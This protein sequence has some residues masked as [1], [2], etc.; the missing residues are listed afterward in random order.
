MYEISPLYH[1]E[2]GNRGT[3]FFKKGNKL[4]KEKNA[5]ACTLLE[6]PVGNSYIPSNSEWCRR[7]QY[8][9][10]EI[11]LGLSAVVCGAQYP[12]L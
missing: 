1:I 3:V 10:V 2:P 5:Y 8:R 7:S 6:R 11:F 12:Y 9:R 4:M